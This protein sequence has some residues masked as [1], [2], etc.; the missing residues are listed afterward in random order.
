[1]ANVLRSISTKIFGI[2]IGL[3]VIMVG[4]ALWA[5]TLTNHVS[6][7]IQTF[8]RALYPMATNLAELRAETILET[9]PPRTDSRSC[10][11][12]ADRHIGHATAIIAELQALRARGAVLS[13]LERNK[14]QMARLEPTLAELRHQ[15]DKLAAR[16]RADC[17]GLGAARD[18]VIRAQTAEVGRLARQANAEMAAFVATGVLVVEANQQEAARA[19]LL[20]ILAAALVGLMLAWLVARGLTRPIA[21]LQAGA[22]AIGEGRLDTVV[23]ITSRDEIGDVTRAFNTMAQELRQKERIT[24]TFGQYV[25]PRVVAGLVA[26]EEDRSSTGEKQVATIFFSDLSGFTALSERLAPATLVNLVNAYFAEMSEPIRQRSGVIDKYIGDAIMAFW[27]PPFADPGTQAAEACAAALDQLDRLHRFADRIPDLIGMRRDVPRIDM[28]IGLATG[29]VVVGSIGSQ[30]ARSFTVMGD[31][32][33]FCA[34]LESANKVY[35]TRILIDEATRTAA[36]EAIEAREIDLVAVLGRTEPIRIFELLAAA[37]ELEDGR[38]RAL[39][40]YEEALVPYRT[41]DWAAARAG[42][43]AVLELEPADRPSQAML[44]RMSSAA[45]KPPKGW[46][47]ISILSQ[48]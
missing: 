48:K 7:Q 8:S 14:L 41:G 30:H 23:P 40:L 13:V 16:L 1:M 11:A 35:G 6:R 25:D 31:T 9:N 29:E 2:S 22:R 20:M 15:H 39:D 21:R 10:L 44:A 42:F 46:A 33:N 12:Y 32:V 36:G 4:T 43:E 47:G 5:A 45:G 28:R 34:R 19:T 3:L 27:V 17:L 38:R 18:P 24:A 26:G 37:G